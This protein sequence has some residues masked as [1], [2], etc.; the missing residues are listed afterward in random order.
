M[1]YRNRL[2]DLFLGFSVQYLG[3]FGSS[4]LQKYPL[5]KFPLNVSAFFYLY[6]HCHFKI[7]SKLSIF[8]K[9]VARSD[10][11]KVSRS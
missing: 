11:S 9:E 3:C 6:I 7:L 5:D 10:I 8:V 2:T 1:L 4:Q